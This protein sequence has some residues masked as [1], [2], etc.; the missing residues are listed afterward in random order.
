MTMAMTM[1]MN[2]VQNENASYEGDLSD[3]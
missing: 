3:Y 1:T 2:E